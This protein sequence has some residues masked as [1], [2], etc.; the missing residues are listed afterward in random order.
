LI[1]RDTCRLKPGVPGLSENIRVISIV[2][3]F[4]EHTRVFHFHNDGQEEFFIGSADLMTRN[5]ESRVEI[6]APIEPPELRSELRKMFEV[7]LADRRAAWDM[8][9]D[10]SYTQRVPKGHDSRKSCQETMMLLTEERH[11]VALERNA[12]SSRRARTGRVS[13]KKRIVPATSSLVPPP[14]ALK[15]LN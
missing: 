1:V 6:L 5:L 9:A 4:L 2:G 14:E 13:K 8:Q 7:Q 11:E 12:K 3:R 10:G 15:K